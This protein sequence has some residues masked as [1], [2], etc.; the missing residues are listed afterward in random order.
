MH[1]IKPTGPKL[2]YI[3]TRKKCGKSFCVFKN[4]VNIHDNALIYWFLCKWSGVEYPAV[5]NH[6]NTHFR[7]RKSPCSFCD[8]KFNS[9]GAALVLEII[10]KNSDTKLMVSDLSVQCARIKRIVQEIIT[11]MLNS[12]R[13]IILV[14]ANIINLRSNNLL[15]YK[16]V[17][18]WN[19]F[20]VF[21]F[22]QNKIRAVCRC[23]KEL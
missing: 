12:I 16:I 19:Q 13:C 23:T 9:N 3:C 7:I 11:D 1:L 6:L 2:E 5:M 8:A 15:F 10:M 22:L 20:V 4:H 17:V 18:A 14:K 21:S